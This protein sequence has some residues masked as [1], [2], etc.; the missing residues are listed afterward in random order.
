M[1]VRLLASR[2][3][4]PLLPGRFLALISA[5]SRV[6]PRAVMRLERLNQLKNLITST[7][8]ELATYRLIAECLYQIVR[9]SHKMIFPDDDTIRHRTIQNLFVRVYF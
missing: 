3:F 8:I 7:G 6:D 4:R 1:E 9:Y 5:R 2:A